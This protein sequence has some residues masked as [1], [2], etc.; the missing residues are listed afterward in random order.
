MER[1]YPDCHAC[2]YRPAESL[3][4]L[5]KY[6]LSSPTRAACM[7]IIYGILHVYL[8][9][10]GQAS[11]P[12]PAPPYAL[13]FR[14]S[15]TQ[16][17]GS[18][19]PASFGASLFSTIVSSTLRGLG[20]A[21]LF[22]SHLISPLANSRLAFRI[23]I[24]PWAA[25]TLCHM[26]PQEEKKKRKKSRNPDACLCSLIVASGTCRPVKKKASPAD[27]MLCQLPTHTKR[28]SSTEPSIKWRGRNLFSTEQNFHQFIHERKGEM[29]T[30]NK[31]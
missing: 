5:Q 1:L 4:P 22:I 20:F 8:A 23:I 13:L 17:L 19:L 6:Q 16:C 18:P 24:T 30:R 7:K 29:S 31:P 2:R 11:F 9:A 21:S 28:S 25:L 12:F 15:Q 26:W 3:A 10:R 14:L 27:A